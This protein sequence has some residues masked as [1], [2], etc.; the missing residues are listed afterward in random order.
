MGNFDET[1][2]LS[3]EEPPPPEAAR[4]GDYELLG[5]VGRG[6]MGVVHR[7]R[8]K[9]TNLVVALKEVRPARSDRDV[10]TRRF[11][12][13]IEAASGLRHPHIVPIFHV[14]ENATGP[15][16]TMALIEGGSLEKHLERF[17][18]NPRRPR[19]SWPRSPGQFITPISGECL[20][21]DL[22]PGNVLID[23]AGEPHV[24]DFGLATRLDAEGAAT[25]KA[26]SGSLPW[27]APEAVRGDP[28]LST[29]VDVWASASFF[30]NCSPGCGRSRVTD[31]STMRRKIL[32]S[33]PQPPRAINPKIDRDLDAI[34]LGCLAKDP[35]KRYESAAELASDLDRW[36][37][38]E[39]V[40]ARKA[41][42]IERLLK[43]G[44]RNPALAGGTAF[45]VI[46]LVA[47]T[48]AAISVAHDQEKRVTDEVCRGNE[49]AARH[50]ASTL[51]A[52][53]APIRRCGGIGRRRSATASSLQRQRRTGHRRVLAQK[54]VG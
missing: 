5:E 52:R 42:R 15:Y 41:G 12:E 7:A 13:E 40:Q 32:E 43:W 54:A 17:R 35:E 37:R 2:D 27:M 19:C 48:I 45:L 20:H 4:F 21:R 25:A 9:G 14:G 47:S 53:L 8:L 50:V 29:A 22:K 36:L 34:C 24:A 3:A 33:E 23:E 46:L 49:F 16:Y 28:S 51:I 18:N 6:A 39:P 26:V 44:R 10:A 30:T 38:H 31:R 1:V 11:R